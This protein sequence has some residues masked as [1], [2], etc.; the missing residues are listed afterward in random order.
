MDFNVVLVLVFVV[1]VVAILEKFYL[2]PN[3]SL[4][5]G[6]RIK[7]RVVAVNID[8][9]VVYLTNRLEYLSE[10]C[11]LLLSLDKAK[12]NHN[13]MGTVMKVNNSAL[14]E[15]PF[16]L[17]KFF[18]NVKGILFRHHIGANFKYVIEGQTMLFSVV[19]KQ[20]EKVIL[21]L[22]S[23]YTFEVGRVYQAR[24]SKCLETDL[25]IDV[26]MRTKTSS[27]YNDEDE[28]KTV[29]VLLPIRLLSDHCD[30][31]RAVLHTFT[32]GQY[33]SVLGLPGNIL[34]YRDA[35]YFQENI[36]LKMPSFR[37]LEDGDLL[38]VSV[39]DMQSDVVEV[40]PCL[41]GHNRPQKV[42]TNMILNNVQTTMEQSIAP[43]QLEQIL[44]AKVLAK[45]FATKTISL[46][47]KFTDIWNG[48][49]QESFK[50]CKR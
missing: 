17:V 10:H 12:I 20:N 42:H 50:Y 28:Y 40:M 36:R 43:L 16:A 30:L 48:K 35:K 19:E 41:S 15:N 29:K 25:E 34:S 24:V 18:N 44:Y 5:I 14:P 1:S 33:I 13:Y 32:P 6:S 47:M 39:K 26:I 46:S 7:C 3:L 37:G 31:W 49:L 23:N 22:A 38:R 21:G 4:K 2:Q 27:G 9:R 11:D 8:R 45:D